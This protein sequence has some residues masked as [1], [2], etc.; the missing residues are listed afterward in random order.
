[1]TALTK[2]K[3]QLLDFIQAFQLGYGYY[4]TLE[5]IRQKFKL[6]SLSTVH[7]HL[8]ELEDMGMLERGYGKARDMKMSAPDPYVAG[9]VA[10]LPIAGLITAGLP[11]EAIEDR[12]ETLTVPRHM[13]DN[14]NAYVLKVKGD[15]M[16][17]SLIDDGDY[18]VV[19]KQDYATDGD[20]VVALLEDGTATLKEYH[21]EKNY[22]RLQPRNTKYR[23]IKVRNV[24]IQGRVLGIIRKY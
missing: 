19:Q 20:I 15:S 9:S 2:K 1:M 14:K 7:Q 12:T 22:V 8:S 10:E 18:V 17:E 3:K 6:S 5:E 13:I 4:P 24:I 21:R 11:I 23:P 16:I